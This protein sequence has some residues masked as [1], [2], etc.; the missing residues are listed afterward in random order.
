MYIQLVKDPRTVQ[1]FNMQ[2]KREMEDVTSKKEC[3]NDLPVSGRRIAQK[4]PMQGSG[5]EAR[6][7]MKSPEKY[8][9]SSAVMCKTPPFW[10]DPFR[11]SKIT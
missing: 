6:G 10:S 8:T 9:T 4:N 2:H 7:W 1:K 5:P 3:R 11:K